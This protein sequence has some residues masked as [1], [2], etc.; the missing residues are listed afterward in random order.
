[1]P[2]EKEDLRS[3][4][5]IVAD[6]KTVEIS[7]SSNAFKTGDEVIIIHRDDYRKF[8]DGIMERID[9][10]DEEVNLQAEFIS[11]NIK[12]KDKGLLGKFKIR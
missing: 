9:K 10:L 12:N 2:S 5:G 8:F 11:K 6:L 4:I 7:E 3:A 1:M